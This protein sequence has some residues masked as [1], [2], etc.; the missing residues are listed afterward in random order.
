M[1][2]KKVFVSFNYDMNR[3]FKNLLVT[4]DKN[5]EYSFEFYDA[6]LRDLFDSA[7]GD[8]LKTKIRSMIQGASEVLFIIGEKCSRSKWV[9]W[10]AEIAFEMGKPVA[11]VKVD[12]NCPGPKALEGKPVTWASTFDFAAIRSAIESAGGATATGTAA[13]SAAAPPAA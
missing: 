9:A 3:Y 2:A 11:A 1:A 5:H 6:S 12:P 7:N 8:F 10:E 4:G 13:S